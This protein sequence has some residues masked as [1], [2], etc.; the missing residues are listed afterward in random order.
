M[1][2]GEEEEEEFA[3]SVRNDLGTARHKSVALSRLC[4][5]HKIRHSFPNM[6]TFS[7][8]KNVQFNP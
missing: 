7:F 4:L 2:E 6:D 8:P 5:L 1:A 3:E